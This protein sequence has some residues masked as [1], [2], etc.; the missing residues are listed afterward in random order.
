MSTNH[1]N[2][3]GIW[4]NT[5]LTLLSWLLL[6]LSVC[7]DDNNERKENSN[8]RWDFMSGDIVKARL[9]T[10]N[11][12]SRSFSRSFKKR[13]MQ[14][15]QGSS[16]QN[17]AEKVYMM[18]EQIANAPAMLSTA[19]GNLDSVINKA[20]D[21][22]NH[23]KKL[24]PPSETDYLFS[25]NYLKKSTSDSTPKPSSSIQP[26]TFAVP[27]GNK[28]ENLDESPFDRGLKSIKTQNMLVV[29]RGLIGLLLNMD[30]TCN[31]DLFLL[32]CKIIA[33]LVNAC[34]ISI[35]LCSIMTTQQLLQLVRIAVWENQ[36]HPWAVHAITCLLQDILEADR[37]YKCSD[38][39]PI[40]DSNGDVALAQAL[41]FN[42]DFLGEFS[43]SINFFQRLLILNKN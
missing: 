14:N 31:M 10:S 41:A 42:A 28:N 6:F 38:E 1:E 20:Q 43:F 39:V 37:S 36:Q 19:S 26:S 21:L 30:F 18:S 23:L 27:P 4:R 8:P 15:K 25:K 35:Q 11:S 7:L 5:D 9:S 12:S 32:T 29:I 3:L 13:F 22:K 17:I 34:K 16:N 24:L 40:D 2:R 33:K